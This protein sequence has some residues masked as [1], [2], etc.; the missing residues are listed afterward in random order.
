MTTRALDPPGSGAFSFRARRGDS[1]DR[2]IRLTRLDRA[3]K[4]HAGLVGV[5]EMRRFGWVAASVAGALAFAGQ[6]SAALVDVT[7]TGLA[8]RFD[9]WLFCT[10]ASYVAT[11]FVAHYAFDEVEP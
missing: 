6:A 1:P 2:G 7:Y 9:G 8:T 10:H 3:S 5:V 11:P 4:V